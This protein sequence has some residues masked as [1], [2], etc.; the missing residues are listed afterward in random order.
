MIVMSSSKYHHVTLKG[1][2]SFMPKKNWFGQ[3]GITG[4]LGDTYSIKTN[5]KDTHAV[6]ILRPRDFGK[7]L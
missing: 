4:S 5:L 7:I 3:S 6:M 1:R 2:F